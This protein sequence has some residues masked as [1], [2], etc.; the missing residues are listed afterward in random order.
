M[1]T[2]TP[3]KPSNQ[4]PRRR[5]DEILTTLVDRIGGHFTSSTVFAAPVERG[6]VTVI[7]VASWAFGFG[8]GGGVDATGDEMSERGGEGG[9]GGGIGSPLGHIE[10]RD[11][12]SRFVP[13]VHPGRMLAMC[14]VTA[15]AVGLLSRP[16]KVREFEGK[17]IRASVR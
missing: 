10:I 7:P 15:V 14:C 17:G 8:G 13:V 6:A 9:G 2:E 11:G 16:R 12:K 5:T 1:T 3:V 4:V